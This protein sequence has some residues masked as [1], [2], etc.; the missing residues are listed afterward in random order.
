M[1]ANKGGDCVNLST[2]SH[3]LNQFGESVGSWAK[4]SSTPKV[5]TCKYC[6]ESSINFSKGAF[7]LLRH[8][9]TP[10]HRKNIPISGAKVQMTLDE[11]IEKRKQEYESKKAARDLE[12]RMIRWAARHDIPFKPIECLVDIV[13]SAEPKSEVLKH[14]QISETKARYLA[15]YGISETY[16]QETVELLRE[17]DGFSVSFDESEMNR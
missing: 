14:V 11:N 7:V 12:I 6:P 13:K 2:V 3:K 9:E 10:K 5:A 16:F 15:S 4:P 17:S 1:P 8:S